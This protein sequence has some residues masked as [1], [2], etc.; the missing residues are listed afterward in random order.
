[1]FTSEFL[2]KVDLISDMNYKKDIPLAFYGGPTDINV[3]NY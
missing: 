3:S 2:M 1:M